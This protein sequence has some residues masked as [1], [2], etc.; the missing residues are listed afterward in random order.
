[1]YHKKRVL[2]HI[3]TVIS[4]TASMLAHP[5]AV[6]GSV[7]PHSLRCL[8]LVLTT[9]SLTFTSRT[10]NSEGLSH[11]RKGSRAVGMKSCR[12]SSQ[13]RG[14]SQ[15]TRHVDDADGK[16]TPC[17][18]SHLKYPMTYSHIVLLS[19]NGLQIHIPLS[20]GASRQCHSHQ[21]PVFIEYAHTNNSSL[22]V[23]MH[24]RILGSSCKQTSHL[25]FMS[26]R[27][28]LISSKKA[29]AQNGAG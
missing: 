8:H 16:F 10:P 5:A 14:F 11:G 12:W 25:S 24:Q 13:G 4:L 19:L 26:T 29:T 6:N 18:V 27:S 9:F 1:M 7:I 22:Y 20:K 15:A 17:L 2:K 28:C 23:T 21:N 3:S